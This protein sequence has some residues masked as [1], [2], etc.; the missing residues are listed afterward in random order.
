[1]ICDPAVEL[2][3][4]FWCQKRLSRRNAVPDFRDQ[5]DPFVN[6]QSINPK[7]MKHRWHR[8]VLL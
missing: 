1:M 7:V 8:I 4:L 6:R 5:G 2:L 3:P